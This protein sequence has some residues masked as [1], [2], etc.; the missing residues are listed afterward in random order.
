MAVYE[1]VFLEI[2]VKRVQIIINQA[3]SAA[4]RGTA[5][6]IDMYYVVRKN[7]PKQFSLFME[8]P[9]KISVPL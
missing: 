5:F 4:S 6:F 1:I 7:K 2:I 9:H 3:A 8:R